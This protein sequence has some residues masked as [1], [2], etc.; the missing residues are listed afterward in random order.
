MASTRIQLIPVSVVARFG[1]CQKG[2][3]AV[4]FAFLDAKAGDLSIV[5]D[6]EGHEE[7]EGRV[8]SDQIV[9]IVHLVVLPKECARTAGRDIASD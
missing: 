9:E 6:A 3:D 2:V 7:I 4:G 5:V 8:S 1:G